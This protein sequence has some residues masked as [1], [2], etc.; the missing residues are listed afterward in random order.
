MRTLCTQCKEP[1]TAVPEVVEQMGL[2]RFVKA[3]PVTLYHAKGC[4]NCAQTGYS[5]RISIIEMML[6]TDAMRTLIMKHAT[7]T[8][9]KALAMKE[10]ML[11]MYEDGMRKAVKGVTTVEE[12]LRATRED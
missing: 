11:T 5:G 2:K 12:V 3:G 7:A 6:M 8:D 1:Y 9:L 4:A 10:G